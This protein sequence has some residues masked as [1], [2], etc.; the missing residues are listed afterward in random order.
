MTGAPVRDSQAILIADDPGFARDLMSRWQ[1]EPGLPGITVMPTDLLTEVRKGEFDLAMVGAVRNKRL[2]SVLKMV[3]AG[4]CPVICL[5]EKAAD[6]KMAKSGYP[7]LHVMHLHEEWLDSLLP[8]ATECLKR[9][10]LAERVRR[11]EQTALASSR[12]ATLG[13][14]MLESRHDLNNSLTSVLGNAEL[15]LLDAGAFSEPVRDQ[16][17]TIHEMA[18]HM[19][20]IMQ[21]FSSVA[22]E[23]R[24]AENSSQ[25]ETDKSSHAPSSIQ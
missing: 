4:D 25:G 23:I 17:Q 5:L 21:R 24:S 15:L 19:H 22:A 2:A 3:D 12:G 20:E 6:V 8:L 10:D 11:A 1:T 9:V 18:L 16:L 13:R 14:Y 7:R